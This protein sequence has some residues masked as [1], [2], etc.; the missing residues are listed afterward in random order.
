M[1]RFQ[2]GIRPGDIISYTEM[3][4]TEGLSLQRGMNFRSAKRESILLM[5]RRENAPYRDEIRD[6]GRTIIY[7]GHDVSKTMLTPN[8]KIYD[9]PLALDSGKPTANGLFFNAAK[10]YK[11]GDKSSEAV[12]VYEKIRTGIWTYNGVFRLTDAWQES[13]GTRQV[14]KLR[15]EIEE[16]NIPPKSD[17]AD[18]DHT[19]V[20]P[21]S[22]KLEVWKRDQG[23][24][25]KCGSSDN[26]H[27]DHIIPFSRGGTSL[28]AR[29]IQLLCAR[30]NIMKSDRLE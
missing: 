28:E 15:L 22:V 29:N 20:I 6:E 23:R 7:E 10:S 26:L 21:P 2:S 24:C 27:F 16:S 25:T 17:L 30:H 4:S 12:R 14:V 5:S 3:C 18:L 11:V 13:D 1:A 9:Q 19:R 8:P